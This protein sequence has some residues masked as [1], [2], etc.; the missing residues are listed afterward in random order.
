MKKF[1]VES[2][3]DRR[4]R[5]KDRTLSQMVH[6]LKVI[7]HWPDD[8]ITDKRIGRYASTGGSPCSCSLGCG[9]K[10][11]NLGATMAEKRSSQFF[12]EID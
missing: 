5:D 10:R 6:L 8:A 1:S 7:Q 2:P 12:V 11:K 3:R 9:H 4:R